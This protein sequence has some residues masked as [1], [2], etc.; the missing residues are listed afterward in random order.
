MKNIF[1]ISIFVIFIQSCSITE[2]NEWHCDFTTDDFERIE[3][4]VDN[5]GEAL[6]FTE[7][8]LMNPSIVTLLD[9]NCLAISEVGSDKMMW[10]ID[11]DAKRANGFITRGSGPEELLDLT[12]MSYHDGILSVAG[13]ND[14]KVLDF[15]VNYDSLKLDLVNHTVLPYIQPMRS[16]HLNDSVIL[17]LATPFSGDRYYVY[18][19]LDS[20]YESSGDFPLDST[21]IEMKPDN[22]FI[23]ADIAVNREKNI[24]VV[25]NRWWGIIE[26]CDLN[27]G[28]WNRYFGPVPTEAVVV[29]EQHGNVSRYKQKPDWSAWDEVYAGQNRIYLGYNGKCR[30]SSKESFGEVK[31]IYTMSYDGKPDRIYSFDEAIVGFTIDEKNGFIYI[32][33]E[34]PEPILVRYP[35]KSK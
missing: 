11:L 9:S 13:L 15:K 20:T 33:H 16:I 30:K 10:L 3:M 27:S 8:I 35:L 6:D 22:A 17:S 4:T 2:N 18:N 34:L 29:K 28:E 24:M 14:S 26:I 1:L 25:A 23:Q 32:I 12:T 7:N 5:N 21:L 31:E 19:M